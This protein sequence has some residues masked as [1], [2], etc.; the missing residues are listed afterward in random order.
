MDILLDTQVILWANFSSVCQSAFNECHHATCLAELGP[1]SKT[2]GLYF[3]LNLP[4]TQFPN[5]SSIYF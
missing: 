3:Y 5:I 1:T 4:T 2:G